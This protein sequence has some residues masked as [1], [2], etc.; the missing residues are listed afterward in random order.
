ML[1]K[2]K[3]IWVTA[4]IAI[5]TRLVFYALFAGTMFRYYHQVS[6]LDMQ[7]LLHFSEWGNNPDVP[8]FFTIHRTVIYLLWKFNNGVHAVDALFL[9]QSISG[10]LGAV[11]VAD[12]ILM[13]TGRRKAALAGGVL[14]AVYLP[15]LIYEFSVLQET[16]AVNVLLFAVWSLFY[17]RKRHFALLPSLSSGLLWGLSLTGRPVAVPVVLAAV[18][19]VFL[20]CRRRKILKNWGIFLLGIL[21]T[22]GGASVFNHIHGWK[23]GPFYNVLPYTV[24][25]NTGNTGTSGTV[26]SVNIQNS[27]GRKLLTT[28]GKMLIRTP[29]MLSVR[30][31]PENQNIYFWRHK[32]PET[33]LL[34]GPEILMTLTVFSL[35]VLLFS[36]AWKHKEGVILWIL[37]MAP[38]LCG[39]EAIGRYRL[40]LCPYFI[41]I[42][43]SGIAYLYRMKKGRTKL[44]SGIVSAVIALSAAVYEMNQNHGL[45]LSDFHSWA[46]ATESVHGNTEQTLDAYYDYWQ[47]SAMR[48]NRAF[49]A[50]QGAAMRASRFDIAARVIQQAELAGGVNRS[51][52][53]YFVGLIHVGNNDPY[54]VMAA[55][56]NIKPEELPPDLQQNYHMVKR[57]SLRIIQQLQKN[58]LNKQ[59]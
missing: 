10:I 52:I 14:Y 13:L 30:E 1:N 54:R 25:Y 57:D 28:A 39:R 51:L 38:A 42:A 41:I 31:L 47:R 23:Y 24:Q 20:W 17:A 37:L 53:A 33:S 44:I 22:A 50:M 43:V 7:T 2:R 3:I 48:N 45:R 40:M 27:Y 4:V 36:G 12:L 16:F 15:F 32:M 6:G 56:S 18:T 21:L 8:P 34:P 58:Q 29:Q 46:I 35:C 49:Q 19:G 9:L 59:P 11:A 5:I 55:F 26:K